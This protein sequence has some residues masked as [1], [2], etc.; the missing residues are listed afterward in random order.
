MNQYFVQMLNHFLQSNS[1]AAVEVHSVNSNAWVVLDAQIDVFANTEAKVTSFG[2]VTLPQLVF[3]DLE[4]TLKNLLCLWAADGDVDS[5]LFVTTDTEGSDGVSGLAWM[6]L[7][8]VC[9]R[10]KFRMRTVDWSLTTQLFEH[11][12]G[13]GEPITRLADRDVQDEFL[14]AQLPHGVAGLVGCFFSRL[15]H[16]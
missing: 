13:T 9:E 6:G 1:H 15:W 3:L 16:C 8:V 2:E 11:L 12:C 14:D 5:D 10:W 4:A 7:E